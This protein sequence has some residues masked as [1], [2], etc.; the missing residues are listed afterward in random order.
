MWNSFRPFL[1]HPAVDRTCSLLLFQASFAYRSF[2]AGALKT[3][4]SVA[5]RFKVKGNG[6]LLRRKAGKAHN[7]GYKS[8]GRVNRL[9]SSAPIKDKAI[10]K[11]MKKLLNF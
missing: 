1:L 3:N 6:D 9:A 7:T 4:K 11:K 5:K 8:R 2:A 10:E